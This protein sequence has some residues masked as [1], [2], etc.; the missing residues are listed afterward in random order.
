MH[1]DLGLGDVLDVV[2]GEFAGRL[3]PL[4]ATRAAVDEHVVMLDLAVRR[5]LAARLARM[6]A[7]LGRAAVRWLRRAARGV[8]LRAK[9]FAA[10]IEFGFEFRDPR[11]LR[12]EGGLLLH[13]SRLQCGNPCQQPFAVIHDAANMP[14]PA[15]RAKSGLTVT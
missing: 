13:A 9:A 14:D 4:A 15:E 3:H 6:L 8:R 5:R 10:A 2:V 12:G 1:F 7:M 11:R